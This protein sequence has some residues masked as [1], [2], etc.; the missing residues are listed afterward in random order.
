MSGNKEQ[1]FEITRTLNLPTCSTC[2]PFYS[3][4]LIA[5]TM[6]LGMDSVLTEIIL[7]FFQLVRLFCKGRA[8]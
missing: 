3:Y 7:K 6:R 4:D 8:R 1:K 5:G 2:S